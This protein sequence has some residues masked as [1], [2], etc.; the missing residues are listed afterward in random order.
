MSPKRFFSPPTA[1]LLDVVFDKLCFEFSRCRHVVLEKSI[2]IISDV[3]GV[4]RFMC[5]VA[6]LRHYI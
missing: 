6:K 2:L 4:I 3:S 1:L 5:S